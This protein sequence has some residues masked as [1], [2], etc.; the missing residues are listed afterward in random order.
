MFIVYDER[1][2]YGKQSRDKI[3]LFFMVVLTFDSATRR[4]KKTI[5]FKNVYGKLSRDK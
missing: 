4:S 2:V 5:N 3:K 1:N